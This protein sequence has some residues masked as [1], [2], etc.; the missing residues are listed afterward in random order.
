MT[1]R[2]RSMVLRIGAVWLLLMCLTLVASGQ[3]VIGNGGFEKADGRGEVA[4][5]ASTSSSPGAIVLRDSGGAHGGEGCLA[6]RHD[7][8]ASSSALS[9]PVRLEVGKIYRLSGWIRT[10]HADA[11]PMSRYPTAVAATLSMA[12]FPFTLFSPPAGGT[13]GWWKSEILFV[14]TQKEDR[15][16]VTLGH[17]GT[18]SGRAWFDDVTLEEVTNIAE[19][20]PMETVRWFG[21]AFRYTDQGWTFVHIEGEPYERGYQ[22]GVLLSAEIVTYLEKLAVNANQDNPRLGWEGLRT[23]TDAMLLRKYDEEYLTEMKGIADGAAK[24]GAQY[25]G[26]PLDL[27]DVVA[28]N[29][30]V[31]LGQ[32]GGALAK[33]PTSLTGRSFRQDE[34][35]MRASE[36]LHKCSSFLANGP[37]SRDGRIVFA[38]LFMWG[39]YTGVHWDVICDVV[40]AKGHRLVYETFPGGIHSGS[41]FYINSA[42]IMIGETTVMQTPFNIDGIPQSSRIRRAAQYASS[43]DDV[44]RI[45]TEKNNGLYT[46]DWLIGDVRANEIAILLLGTKTYKLWRSKNG[47]FPGGTKG[48][49]WSVNNAKDPEVRKEYV[50]DPSNAPFD[51]TFSPV[52]RDI[53]FYE[54]YQREKGKIDAIS[55]VNIVASSPLNRPHACDGKVTTS[56]MAEKMVFWAHYGKVTL[57]EKFPERGSR[58]MPDLPGAIPHLTLG[59]TAFSPVV[60]TDRLQALRPKEESGKNAARGVT[61]WERVKEIYSWDRKALWLNTVYPARDADNW[62]VSGTAAYWSILNSLPASPEPAAVILRDQLA[63]INSRLLYTISR[64]GSLTPSATTRRYDGYK[65]YVIPRAR[66]T[67]LL[68]QLRLKLGNRVFGDVMND[69]HSRFRDRPMST[70]EFISRSEAVAGQN[71]R[72]FILQ[73]LEREDVPDPGLKATVTKEGDQWKVSLNVEQPGIPYQFRA[74]VALETEKGTQWEVVEITRSPE[75]VVLSCHARPTRLRFNAGNDIPVVSGEFY[76]LANLFDDFKNIRILYGTMRQIEANHTLALRYQFVLADAFT[77][78]LLPV[79]QENQ[80]GGDELDSCDVILLGGAADNEVV[81]AAVEDR[82]VKDFAASLGL[83]VGK[84]MFRWQGKTFGNP[85]EGLFLALANPMGKKRVI[86]L[87]LANSAMELYHMTKRHQSLPGWALFKGDQIVDRGYRLVDG[88]VVDLNAP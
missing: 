45:L 84:N 39:G 21:P 25:A 14:A 42:G 63:E 57:R 79:R 80:R 70:A 61:D 47:D 36:R 32:L 1:Y 30:S 9:A 12:S 58:R 62:F 19:Y 4:D 34:E 13:R 24:A 60:V 46:N 74:T 66:G 78:D 17:N 11:N 55:A 48:F 77:E 37:A 51:V 59:Y 10:D 22:Y 7:Q 73:W 27:L 44:V 38:Q 33:T 3:V 15:V 31:D 76:T 83:V 67:F 53:A 71:L 2:E 56:E 75:N 68:H 16:R 86:Y 52:N 6:I 28:V 23:L 40:P 43:V 81:R 54:Y 8:A 20:I 64:E 5:W 69:L 18:A 82:S 29:S 85:D 50:P 72:P 87:F 26:R 49:Y 65:T 35:E 41:D 88:L